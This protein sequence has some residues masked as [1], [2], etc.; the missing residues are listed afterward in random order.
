MGTIFMGTSQE[1]ET[2]H[3]Y[4]F[5]GYKSGERNLAYS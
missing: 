4:K 1:S 2:F 3:G 5:H